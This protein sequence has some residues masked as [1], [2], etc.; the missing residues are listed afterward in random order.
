MEDSIFPVAGFGF[1][2]TLVC[3]WPAAVATGFAIAAIAYF[4]RAKHGEE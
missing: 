2:S 4:G 3:G 1:L